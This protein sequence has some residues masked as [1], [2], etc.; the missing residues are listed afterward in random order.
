VLLS[1]GA[2]GLA[3][4]VALGLRAGDL[5]PSRG[6]LSIL[7]DFFSRA[8]TPALTYESDSIPSGS[9]PFLLT[10]LEGARRTVVFAI[11][12]ISLSLVSGVVLGFL[13]STAWW[14]GD[15]AGGRTR[16]G[17]FS[18]RA[19][20]PSVYAAVRVLIALMRSV[21]ELLWAVLFLA[22]FGFNTFAAVVA[23]SIPYGG[24]LAKIFSEMIDESSR[25]SAEGL[26]AIGA[27]PAG[28]FFFG[29]LPRALTDMVAYTFYRTECAI[30]SAAILGFFG[31]ETLGYHVKSSFDNLH[32]GE[33]W[34]CLYALFLLVLAVDALSGTVRRRLSAR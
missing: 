26:R 8:L 28:V 18:R 32:Y 1:I 22:A 9:T 33:V 30:R 10:V 29:L 6:G 4:Y 2:A 27:T 24:T 11:A 14:E 5:A 7:V 17:R 16:L 20:R 25:D 21:H 31:Y 23:I 19:V 12:A 3:A 34:T 15:P 13:G